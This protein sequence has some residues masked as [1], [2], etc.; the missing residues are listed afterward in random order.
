MIKLGAKIVESVDERVDFGAGRIQRKRIS[1]WFYRLPGTTLRSREHREQVIRIL[2]NVNLFL[3][4]LHTGMRFILAYDT[5][6]NSG[7]TVYA[8]CSR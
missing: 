1:R 6:L 2:T 4:R 8:R 5:L 7:Q 3:T